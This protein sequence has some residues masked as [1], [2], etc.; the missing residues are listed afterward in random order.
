[1]KSVANCRHADNNLFIFLFRFISGCADKTNQ[2]INASMK[3]N[4]TKHINIDTKRRKRRRRERKSKQ[5]IIDIK[6][7]PYTDY[8]VQQL[9]LWKKTQKKKNKREK[10]GMK[11][12]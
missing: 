12:K 3:Q 10:Y 2:W 6:K 7:C 5:M 4:E 9:L 8:S 1:M 11:V